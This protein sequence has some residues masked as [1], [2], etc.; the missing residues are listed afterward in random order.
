M[1]DSTRRWT[2][3]VAHRVWHHHG[4]VIGKRYESQESNMSARKLGRFAGLVFVLAALFAGGVGAA[5]LSASHT[6]TSAT[7][8]S[9]NKVNSLEVV[10]D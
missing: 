1:C 10:W 8:Q 5:D 3:P 9:A 4:T 2:L 7:V 6:G